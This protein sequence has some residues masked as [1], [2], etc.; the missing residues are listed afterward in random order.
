MGS[1]PSTL[2]ASRLRVGGLVVHS[3]L[4]SGL[5]IWDPDIQK[6]PYWDIFPNVDL[7]E[8]VVAPTFILHGGEDSMINVV[9][10]E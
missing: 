4:S 1:G 2:L 3:G 5:R 6:T 9:H 10:A 7:I 8:D